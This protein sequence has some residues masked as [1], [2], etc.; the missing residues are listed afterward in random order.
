MGEAAVNACKK[1]GY[2]SAGTGRVSAGL[3]GRYYFMEMNTA[4]PGRASRD[5]DGDAGDIVRNQC[6]SRR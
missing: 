1:L 3:A 6:E 5:G 2:S 4:H